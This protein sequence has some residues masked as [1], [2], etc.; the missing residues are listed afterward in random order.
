M[1]GT[2][3]YTSLF[4]LRFSS[5]GSLAGRREAWS[6]GA[7]RGSG[8]ATGPSALGP[9]EQLT[10]TLA[11][12]TSVPAREPGRPR[13][14]LRPHSLGGGHSPGAGGRGAEVGPRFPPV[15]HPHAPGCAGQRWVSLGEW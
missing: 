7:V 1:P 12:L 14:H 6:W 13:R 4:F 8:V 3:V 9:R 15:A 5:E 10:P 11:S 2:Q